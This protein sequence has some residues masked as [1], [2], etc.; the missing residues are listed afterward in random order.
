MVVV[1]DEELAEG[2]LEVE[3]GD[4]KRLNGIVSGL[5]GIAFQFVVRE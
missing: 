3:E 4:L 1:R 5:D 2:F